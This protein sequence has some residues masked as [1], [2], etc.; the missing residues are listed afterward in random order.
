MPVP[1]IAA[2]RLAPGNH[3]WGRVWLVGAGPGDP[4][5]ITVAGLRRLQGADVVIYDRLGAPALLGECRPDALKINVGKQAGRHAVPQEDINALL[6]R[7]AMAGR[8]VVRLKGGDP[9][10]FGRGGEEMLALRRLGIQVDV[11]PGITAASACAAA[12]GIP[13]TQRGMASQVSLITAHQR[14]GATGCD[15]ARLAA[16]DAG[17]LVFY[18]GL[19][20]APDIADGLL[21]HGCPGDTPVALVSNGATPHQQALRCTLDTLASTAGTAGLVSPCLILVGAVVA[22]ADPAIVA[23]VDYAFQTTRRAA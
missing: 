15:W 10:I 3:S 13:L 4:E 18:M 5:L 20:H 2:R 6:A 19:S 21:R 1:E 16:Q 7:H 11:I 12:T 9:F 8:S 14:D 23:Q 22:L 17:T